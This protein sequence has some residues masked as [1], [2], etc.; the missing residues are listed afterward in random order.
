M[1][2]GS[3]LKIILFGLKPSSHL[4]VF[5]TESRKLSVVEALL[6]FSAQVESINVKSQTTAFYQAIVNYHET[7][8]K[9]FLEHGADVDARIPNGR[10]ALGYVL[11]HGK[12]DVVEFLLQNKANE[13]LLKEER[14]LGCLEI[15][16]DIDQ[17]I[18]MMPQR[19]N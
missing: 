12:L 2:Y 18:L 15:G 16:D 14:L 17:G 7:L 1:K 8:A 6:F 9:N 4:T 19:R 5:A 13:K 11:T 3:I 10:T